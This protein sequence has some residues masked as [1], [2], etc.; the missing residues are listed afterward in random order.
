MGPVGPGIVCYWFV[1]DVGCVL[2]FRGS[3]ALAMPLSGS[4][5]QVKG[6][7]RSFQASMD[8]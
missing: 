4:L 3:V 6:V 7:Q 1:S 2:R 8:C 5:V